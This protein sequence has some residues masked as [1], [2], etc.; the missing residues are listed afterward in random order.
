MNVLFSLRRRRLNLPDFLN[1]NA[2]EDEEEE[3]KRMEKRDFPWGTNVNTDRSRS[4][5]EMAKYVSGSLVRVIRVYEAYKP[6]RS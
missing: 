1:M 5:D 3:K 6:Q 4:G 2:Y